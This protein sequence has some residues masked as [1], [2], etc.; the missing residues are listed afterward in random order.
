VSDSSTPADPMP[1]DLSIS[2]HSNHGR[3]ADDIGRR[4]T[5]N[6]KKRKI[7]PKFQGKSTDGNDGAKGHELKDCFWTFERKRPMI[8]KHNPTDFG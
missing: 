1:E 8:W 3:T 2:C 7:S 4:E 6:L 5:R